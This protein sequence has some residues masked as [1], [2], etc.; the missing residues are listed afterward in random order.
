LRR[1]GSQFFLRNSIAPGR[2]PPIEYREKIVLK[3]GTKD[4]RL[5]A[6]GWIS[7]LWHEAV[8]DEA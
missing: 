7:L 8:V 4:D 2:I 1:P 5:A 3:G 6:L